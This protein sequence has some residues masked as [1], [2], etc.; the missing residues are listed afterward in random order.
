MKREGLI[1]YWSG[2]SSAKNVGPDAA[3]HR[4]LASRTARPTAVLHLA[5]S[6]PR[7]K[8]KINRQNADTQRTHG[9]EEHSEYLSIYVKAD[10]KNNWSDKKREAHLAFF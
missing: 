2:S 6:P 5:P 10:E 1:P 7:A 9:K 8:P 4:A 3:A